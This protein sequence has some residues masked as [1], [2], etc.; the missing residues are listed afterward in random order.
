MRRIFSVESYKLRYYHDLPNLRNSILEET[1]MKRIILAFTVT[2]WLLAIIDNTSSLQR[3]SSDRIVYIG[4]ANKVAFSPTGDRLAVKSINTISIFDTTNFEPA[5]E[6]EN[7]TT[8]VDWGWPDT[9]EDA[10]ALDWNQNGSL[11]A[12]PVLDVW[13][14]INIWDTSTVSVKKLDQEDVG[15][16]TSID[17][18][19]QNNILAIS[20]SRTTYQDEPAWVIRLMDTQITNYYDSLRVFGGSYARIT[21]IAWHPDGIWLAS[22]DNNG[23]I[24]LWNTSDPDIEKTN[25]DANFK[26]SF[27]N[28]YKSNG[29]PTINDLTWSP[30]GSFLASA[31]G[32]STITIRKFD[33]GEYPL[34]FFT[35]LEG[36]F[37]SVLAIDWNSDGTLLASA[38]EDAIIRIWNVEFGEVIATFEGH[39]AAIHDLDWSPDD[40]WIITA[41]RDK[42]VRIW[43]VDLP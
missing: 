6:I 2:L 38:G 43:K 12:V 22:S 24:K 18:H 23:A 5:V 37:G 40:K 14:S 7:I 8:K 39:Q 42:T 34:S 41:G 20:A 13:M 1:R 17:W 29:Y 15:A 16:I 10:M 36:H 21:D 9:S 35:N 28:T 4:Y 30:S 32:D 31:N 19:P 25:T 11:L 33:A 3:N 26:G 27:L